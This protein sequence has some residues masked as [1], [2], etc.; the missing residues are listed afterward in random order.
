MKNPPPKRPTELRKN[1]ESE[2]SSSESDQSDEEHNRRE[3]NKPEELPYRRVRPLKP[4]VEVPPV[5][6]R[7]MANRE[8][9]KKKYRQEAPVEQD[10]DLANIVDRSLDLPV[11]VTMCEMLAIAPEYRKKCKEYISRRRVP[12]QEQQVNVQLETDL[13]KEQPMVT[14]NLTSLKDGELRRGQVHDED[15]HGVEAWVVNDPIASYLETMPEG[16]RPRILF[17]ANESEALRSIP[18]IINGIS[19]EEALLDS[20]S[21]IVAMSEAAARRNELTWDPDFTIN[22]QSANGQVERTCGLARNVPFRIGLMTIYLQVHVLDSPAYR[23]LLGRPFDV[24]TKSEVKTEA[25]DRQTIVLTNPSNGERLVLPT[26][27]RGRMPREKNEN[28]VNADSRE[29]NF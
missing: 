28:R 3:I 8:N 26:Y 23:V 5:P 2:D 6:Y 7:Y 14:V 22:M 9:E 4:V 25:D 1:A 15:G 10:V 13:A 19:R 27:C 17:A 18:V 20:G 11:P 12:V 16:V 24:I 29:G 21:Q